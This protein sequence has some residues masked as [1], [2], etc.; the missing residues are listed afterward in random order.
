MGRMTI[1]SSALGRSDCC[2][3]AHDRPLDDGADAQKWRLCGWLMIGVPIQAAAD[4][5]VGEGEGAAALQVI[6]RSICLSVAP[7]LPDR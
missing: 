5:V 1:A 7:V 6:R 3:V 2:H 4:T